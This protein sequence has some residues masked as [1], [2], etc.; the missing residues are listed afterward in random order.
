MGKTN[1]LI[2]EVFWT[3][4]KR[5]AFQRVGYYWNLY[6][7]D[8]SFRTEFRSFWDMQEYIQRRKEDAED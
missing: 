4:D 2:S 5:F 8:G 7:C 3:A 1:A 6:E